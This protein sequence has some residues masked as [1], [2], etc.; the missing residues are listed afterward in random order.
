MKQRKKL[1]I[2]GLAVILV[3][4]AGLAVWKKDAL[5][6]LYTLLTKDAQS[7]SV[8]MAEKQQ[9]QTEKL[10]QDFNITVQAP[11]ADQTKGLLDGKLTQDEVKQ[12]LGLVQQPV[13]TAP[14]EPAPA[15]PQPSPEGVPAPETPAGHIPKPEESRQP[16][17]AVPAP[18]TPAERIPEPE[19]PKQLTEEE[20]KAQVE[21]LVNQCVSELY[22]YEVD[23][24][25]EMGA[26]KKVALKEWKSRPAKERTHETRI[27]FG[28]MW[29]NEVYKVEVRADQTVTEILNRYRGALDDLNADTTVLDDMWKYYCDKKSDTKAYYLNKYLN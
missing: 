12:T 3:T 19:E 27:E 16:T 28:F 24:M 4:V 26:M 2:A 17:E 18:E 23:L 10:E 25:A 6:T 22:S 11:T 7:I 15:G 1:F 9:A 29:L 5:K 21:K 13:E 14:S 20:R 8:N